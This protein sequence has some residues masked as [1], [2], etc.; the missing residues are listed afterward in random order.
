MYH[1]S[2]PAQSNRASWVFLGEITDLDNEPIDLTACSMVFQ[3]DDKDGGPR[4][5]ASTANG[6]LT[7]V[8]VGRFR[9][10]FTV[11]EMHGLEPGTYETGLTLTNDDGTQ[12]IQLSVGPLPIVDGVVA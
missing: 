12:T 3:I 10:F 5:T 7:Y 2:F 4:L 9:W 1:V 6:K 8:D 11:D